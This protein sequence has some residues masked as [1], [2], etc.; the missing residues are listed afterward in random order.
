MSML[1]FDRRMENH[2]KVIKYTLIK[3]T[4]KEDFSEDTNI[5]IHWQNLSLDTFS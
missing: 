2:M 4:L 5:G 3:E 1:H